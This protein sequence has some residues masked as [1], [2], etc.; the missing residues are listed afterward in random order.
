MYTLFMFLD[1]RMIDFKNDSV[2]LVGLYNF[3]TLVQSDIYKSN[4][5]ENVN[6]S[7]VFKFYDMSSA[8]YFLDSDTLYRKQSS[9]SIERILYPIKKMSLKVDTT[10]N[11]INYIL[12]FSELDTTREY[13]YFKSHFFL[14]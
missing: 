6:D 2:E 4:E 12:K 8:V 10:N 3:N 11:N 7:I 5:M 13:S 14:N 1:K 9:A